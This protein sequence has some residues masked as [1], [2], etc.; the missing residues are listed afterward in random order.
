MNLIEL[1]QQYLNEEGYCSE[2]AYY[3]LAFKCEGKNYIMPRTLI[4]LN[5]GVWKIVYTLLEE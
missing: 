3:G 2:E 4:V 1:A 5:G